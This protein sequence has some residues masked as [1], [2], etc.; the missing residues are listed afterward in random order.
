VKP[1]RGRAEKACGFLSTEGGRGGLKLL[2]FCALH[3]CIGDGGA[4]IG[5][6]ALETVSCLKQFLNTCFVRCKTRRTKSEA[7][8]CHMGG[9]VMG[10]VP[11][12]SEAKK[13]SGEK[14]L[15]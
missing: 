13:K 6:E 14:V 3:A 8:S 1:D 7:E 2:S 12:S 10:P 9:R 5:R 11:F 15:L 4:I